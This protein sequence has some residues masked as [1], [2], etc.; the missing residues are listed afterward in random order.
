M[1]TL[2]QHDEYHKK[3]Y[4]GL[5]KGELNYEQAYNCVYGELPNEDDDLI[6]FIGLADNE[7]NKYVP[8]LREALD[9]DLQDELFFEYLYEGQI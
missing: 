8:E 7:M 6:R 1:N 5:F 3:I 4:T 9:Q 2:Q